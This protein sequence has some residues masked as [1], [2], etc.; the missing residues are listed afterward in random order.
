MFSAKAKLALVTAGLGL[1]ALGGRPAF[2]YAQ[3]GP[4]ARAI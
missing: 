2:A 3:D 4:R 1:G